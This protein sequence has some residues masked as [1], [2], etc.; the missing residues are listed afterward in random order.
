MGP[1]P[2]G[3][4]SGMKVTV[5]VLDRSLDKGNYAA[6]MQ[7]DIFWKAWSA[8][9]NILQAGTSGLDD[10]VGAYAKGRMW[11][12]KYPH[13]CSASLVS[14]WVS[15][16]VRGNKV[17]RQTNHH[18]CTVCCVDA[19]LLE[20]EWRCIEIPILRRKTME[21]GAWIK[22]GLC[23]S[24]GGE[25]VILIKYAGMANSIVNLDNPTKEHH[26]NFV[27]LGR[28]KG[29]ELSG[30]RSSESVASEPWKAPTFN[31]EDGCKGWWNRNGLQE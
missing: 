26:F 5:A 23:T 7:W 13:T 21:M 16:R 29:N 8:V 31:M 15:T 2:L 11:I 24:L 12:L 19:C 9:T 10:T 14:R 28:N 22:G 20:A 6:F 25:E 3:G 17:T 30:G 4:L 27:I 1:F 18:H